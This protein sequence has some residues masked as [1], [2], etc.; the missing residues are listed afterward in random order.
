MDPAAFEQEIHTVSSYPASMFCLAVISPELSITRFPVEY[1][2]PH[3]AT[4]KEQ[5]VIA[6]HKV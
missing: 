4:F 3:P 2:L 6:P 1:A 5:A